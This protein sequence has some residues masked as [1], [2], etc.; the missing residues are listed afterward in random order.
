[1]VVVVSAGSVPAD[2]DRNPLG[3]AEPRL[4]DYN[5]LGNELELLQVYYGA[6][7]EH[8][9]LPGNHA[10][11]EEEGCRRDRSARGGRTPAATTNAS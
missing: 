9:L 4:A 11:E 7:G 10:T 6:P 3:L 5:P 2:A 1:M 8:P